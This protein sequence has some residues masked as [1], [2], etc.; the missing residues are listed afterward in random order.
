MVLKDE[1]PGRGN[2]PGEYPLLCR[3]FFLRLFKHTPEVLVTS[4]K[5]HQRY[6]PVVDNQGNLMPVFIGCET[7]PMIIFR[8]WPGNQRVLKARLDDAY[9]FYREDTKEP[10]ESKVKLL[11]RVIYQARLG[12]SERRPGGCRTSPHL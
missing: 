4:M 3:D 9:F 1:A 11:D 5:E 2:L 7:E 10:L 6:F 8:W 12:L